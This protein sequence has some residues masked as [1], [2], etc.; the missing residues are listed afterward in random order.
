[1]QVQLTLFLLMSHAVGAIGRRG[2]HWKEICSVGST[3]GALID[4]RQH[5]RH[6]YSALPKPKGALAW[7]HWRGH[8][9]RIRLSARH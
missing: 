2:L 1:M 8:Q 7:L 5:F 4:N 6:C 9:G 3:V